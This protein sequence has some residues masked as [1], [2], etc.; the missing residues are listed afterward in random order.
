MPPNYNGSKKVTYLGG[1]P[2]YRVPAGE[3][4]AGGLLLVYQ[5]AY[6]T[7]DQPQGGWYS[8]LGI[9][10]STNDGLTWTDLGVAIRSTAPPEHTLTVD[11]GDGDLVDSGTADPTGRYFYIYFPDLCTYSTG[12]ICGGKSYSFGI[13]K[14]MA[15]ARV[16]YEEFLSAA[17]SG[18]P[19]PPP[20][21]EFKKFY[22]KSVTPWLA[23][24]GNFK[25]LYDTKYW[26]EPG[27]GGN[28]TDVWNPSSPYAGDMNVKWNAYLNSFVAIFNT[29]G[30]QIG[31]AF[32]PD[33]LDWTPVVTIVTSSGN[34]AAN[35]GSSTLVGADEDPNILGSKFY[36]FYLVYPTNGTGWN[37]ATLNRITVE[38]STGAP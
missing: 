13:D 14:G 3:P 22:D 6:D 36:A 20:L 21:P 29:G 10:K 23:P 35:L 9:A 17:F 33:G 28:S 7:D 25:A 24:T 1:G 12:G 34:P 31:Y 16:D 2:V 19:T 38:C 5:G 27:I 11:I 30:H 32:S 18:A 37:D 26:Q 4:G 8:F 15:V